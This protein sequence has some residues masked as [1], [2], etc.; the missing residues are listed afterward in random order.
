ME[1]FALI[2]TITVI[3]AYAHLLT[4]SGAYRHRPDATQ[5]H[6][7]T[8]KAGLISAAPWLILHLITFQ[9]NVACISI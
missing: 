1:R 4:A 3:W 7:R 9:M 8:D 6:C 5:N 2:I